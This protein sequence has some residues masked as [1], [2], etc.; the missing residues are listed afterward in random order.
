MQNSASQCGAYL[1]KLIHESR[2][3]CNVVLGSVVMLVV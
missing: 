2:R 3:G 1:V